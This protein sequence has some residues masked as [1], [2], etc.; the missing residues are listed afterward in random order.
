M[1]TLKYEE[2]LYKI[3]NNV[4]DWL[5]FAE[6]KNLGLLTLNIAVA[7]G[8]TQI[9]FSD[10]CIIQNACYIFLFFAFLS[11]IPCLISLFPVMSK[12]ELQK[13]DED[14]KKNKNKFYKWL[15]KNI[16]AFSNWIEPEVKLENI[17]FYGYIKGIEKEVFQEK[18]L[19]KVNQSASFTEYEV[20]L[21]S[22]II[23]NSRITW[24]KFQLFKIGAYLFLLGIIISVFSLP[25]LGLLHLFF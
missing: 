1:E 5:K 23:Y 7:F 9:N 10:K 16:T 22:Q 25:V 24:F 14:G 12:I 20:E 2:N 18:F 4:N 21:V 15:K 8:F 17:H 11:F 13:L 19:E 6:A 3:F